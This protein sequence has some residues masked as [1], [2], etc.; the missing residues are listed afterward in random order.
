[1]KKK[2]VYIK[3][4]GCKVNSFDSQA[5]A[6]Q[7]SEAGYELVDSIKE[8]NTVVINSCSVTHVAEKEARY[9]LRRY[10]RENPEARRVLTGCYAQINSKKILASENLDYLV[11]NEEKHKLVQLI[12]RDLFSPKEKKESPRKNSLLRK[13]NKANLNLHMSCFLPN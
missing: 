4:L 7:F 10:Q 12:E 5:L 8:A 6:T 11:P 9:L 1:M 2:S 13:I 3:T